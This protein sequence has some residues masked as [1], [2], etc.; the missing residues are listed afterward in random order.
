MLRFSIAAMLTAFALAAALP[1]NAGAPKAAGLF[2]NA[3]VVKLYMYE[4]SEKIE[5]GV[6]KDFKTLTPDAVPST[7]VTLNA[8]QMAQVKRAFT[9]AT[10]DQA[11]G[12]CFI[13]RHGFVFEDAAGKVVGTLDVCFECSNY[14]IDAPGYREKAK[15]IYD[16]HRQPDGDWDEK[17]ARKQTAEINRLRAEY[18][19]APTDAPIDWKGLAAIVEAANMPTAPKPA[20]YERLRIA[21]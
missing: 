11:I 5:G 8:T 12:A 19:M 15:A 18:N 21:N 17:I 20:D 2:P 1:A 4:G 14:S 10:G 6:M 16:R 9:R 3:T 7:G 13:P